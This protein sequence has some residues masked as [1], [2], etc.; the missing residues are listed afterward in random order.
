MTLIPIKNKQVDMLKNPRTSHYKTQDLQGF[1]NSKNMSFKVELTIQSH[2]KVLNLRN[3][4]Q[5]GVVH[6]VQVHCK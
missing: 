2:T 6:L 3:Q 4:A 1:R 5:W